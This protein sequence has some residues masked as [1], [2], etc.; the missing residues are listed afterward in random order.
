MEQTNS[1]FH[2]MD[3]PRRNRQ[4]QTMRD[5]IAE[6]HLGCRD[7][8]MPLFVIDQTNGRQTISSMPGIDRL[9]ESDI[10]REIEELWSLGIK[11]VAL[12]PKL[13]DDRKDSTASASRDEKGLIPKAIRWIKS[14]CPEMLVI[15]DV[16]MDPYSSD[17]HDGLVVDGEVVNDPS[18]EILA[19]M[20][21]VQA[22]AGADV[23]APS[24]M[25]DGRVGYIREALDTQGLTQTAIL[26]YSVKYASAFYGPFREAL[27]SAPRFGDKKTY[28]MD[29]RNAREALREVELDEAQGADMVM[30]KPALAYLDVIHQVRTQTQLP[31]AAYHVSGEY[32]M[33]KAAGQ[34][35]WIDEDAVLHEVLLSIKRA[36]A[37]C[38]LS[39]GAKQWAQ[40]H[41]G[42]RV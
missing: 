25:M 31:V 2:L 11:A 35:G 36:G 17:G 42:D 8:I 39:Y 29:V 5:L 37:D 28:Q 26:A 9:G 30:I 7:L 10:K 3:R 4:S 19:D 27:G 13:D 22:Q 24:D 14:V 33:I 20:A 23:V 32:A 38:I 6:T 21:V 34:Q 16:A 12:F 18:L 41:Q 40:S 1:G 15:T